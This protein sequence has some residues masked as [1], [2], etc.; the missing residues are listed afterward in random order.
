MRNA[1][2]RGEP[3]EEVAAILEA[4]SHLLDQIDSTGRKV[5][6]AKYGAYAFFDYDGEP[7][8]VGQTTERLRTRIRRHL[9]NQRTDAVAMSVLDPF[10]VA[11]IEMWPLWDLTA[12]P[13]NQAEI[14]ERLN[15]AEYTV[16]Q[17]VVAG[18]LFC[19][20]LNEVPVTPAPIVTLPSSVRGRI[21]PDDIY[22]RRLHS[23]IRIARRANTIAR[24]A[25]IISERSVQPGLRATLLTQA[26]RLEHLASQ[27]LE[28]IGGPPVPGENVEPDE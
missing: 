10:E 21:V 13:G 27:R 11:E 22:Q 23:D 4:L 12:S 2:R 6:N 7:I 26:R 25:Q 9:T 17:Q 16:F 28:E 3:P 15:S 5:G 8:Y 18:S 19:A 24:L 14:K 1:R 20:V